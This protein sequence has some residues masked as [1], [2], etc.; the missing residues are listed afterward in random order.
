MTIFRYKLLA[1]S[2][3]LLISCGENEKPLELPVLTDEQKVERM[4]LCMGEISRWRDAGVWVHGGVEPAVNRDRWGELSSEDQQSI[5]DIAACI[6]SSGDW[7]PQE[8]QIVSEGFKNPIDRL[9]SQNTLFYE[10]F[11]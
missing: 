9:A 10:K 3:F 7:V 8:V 1:S 5:A 2:L 4:Q 11:Q 6:Q